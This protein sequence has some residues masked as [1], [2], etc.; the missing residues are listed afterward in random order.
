M[1]LTKREQAMQLISDHLEVLR[2]DV[3]QVETKWPHF[4]LLLDDLTDL[5]GQMAPG[6]HVVLMERGLLYG[7][8]SLAA[9]FFAEQTVSTVDCSPPSAKKRGAYNADMVVDPRFIRV[10]ATHRGQP[11]K[12][13]L[14]D[15]CADLVVV[16]NLV[17]HI[18]DQD[19]F[20]AEINRILKPGGMAYVFEPLVRELH[21]V[22]DDY[23]R[24]T[25]FGLADKYKQV[26]LTPQDPK[27]EGGP[28]S[29]VAYCWAQA[30]EY[31]P[32]PARSEKSKWF[33]GTHFQELMALDQAHP[34]N[35]MRQHT[36]FP[37]AYSV[38]AT[39]ALK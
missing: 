34:T 23:L 1:G 14:E 25:P 37:M 2:S 15:A 10:P 21:Q 36:H 9:P 17:H 18:R 32:E 27:L 7:G 26:G 35:N 3:F 20:F 8:C 30:L 5:A 28:F 13:G 39:K 16:P 29:A 19:G 38:A 22:P 6:A 31:L 33:Y 11:E 12:T 4:Q 24:Y